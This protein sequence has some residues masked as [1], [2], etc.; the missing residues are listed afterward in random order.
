MFFEEKESSE[1]QHSTPK[2]KQKKKK[3]VVVSR[4]EFIDLKNKIDQIL[5]AVTTQ[6]SPQTPLT[7]SLQFL[8]ERLKEIEQQEKWTA[9]RTTLGIE[10]GTRKLDQQRKAYHKEFIKKS[11]DT[12][13]E[14]KD[15]KDQ[16]VKMTNKQ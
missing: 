15:L 10:M 5:I 8:E 6:Q 7:K 11:E 9:Q 16:L 4:K 3:K 1:S 13:S 14:F 12:T 2:P